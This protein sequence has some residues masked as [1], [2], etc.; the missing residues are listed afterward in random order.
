MS[1]TYLS[2]Q[3]KIFTNRELVK[4]KDAASYWKITPESDRK[5]VQMHA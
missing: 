5:V 1:I 2:K 3:I 4:P